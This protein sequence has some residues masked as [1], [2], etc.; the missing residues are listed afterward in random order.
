[1]RTAATTPEQRT[2][3]DDE[4]N[5]FDLSTRFTVIVEEHVIVG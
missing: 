1:M 3:L 2:V 4:P 5:L